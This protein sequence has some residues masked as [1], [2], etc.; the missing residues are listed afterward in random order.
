MIRR[1]YGPFNTNFCYFFDTGRF[2][3]TKQKQRKALAGYKALRDYEVLLGECQALS[4][5]SIIING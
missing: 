5:H 4:F 3:L 1:G 2:F